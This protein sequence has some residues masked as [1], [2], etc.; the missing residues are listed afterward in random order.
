MRRSRLPILSVVI[1][2]L[3][4]NA[5]G[6]NPPVTQKAENSPCSNIVALTG[7]VK[8]NC[9]SLTPAQQKLIDG[10]PTL[11]R[12]IIAHQNDV[13]AV[14]AK[15]DDCLKTINPNLP[16][17]TYFCNGQW[18]VAGPG[19]HAGFEV[20]M[21]GDDSAFQE[22]V[23]LNNS[24]QYAE[25]L[26][27]C[28]AE[29]NSQPGWLTPRLFCSLAYLATGNTDDAKKM[30]KEFDSRTGPAYEVDACKQASDHLHKVLQ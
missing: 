24:H 2:L 19:A 29:I 18:R 23:R 4:S 25:L 15:L 3:A 5:I 20:T 13:D 12:N 7:D 17:K 8:I 27:T 22:M 6:Q 11:L 21:G 1:F 26:K 30:L 16:T 10:I 9:S 14:M 28:L